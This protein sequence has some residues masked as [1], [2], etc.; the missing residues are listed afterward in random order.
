MGNLKD[1]LAVA[2]DE[3]NGAG[4]LFYGNDEEYS[5]MPCDCKDLTLDW[6]N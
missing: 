3:C 6:N 4:F 5:V 1:I 2:C